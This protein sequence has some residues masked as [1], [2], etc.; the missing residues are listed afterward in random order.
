MGDVTICEDD[1]RAKLFIPVNPVLV[2]KL[3]IRDAYV[4]GAIRF[5]TDTEHRDTVEDEAGLWWRTSAAG[6]AAFLGMAA[7]TVRASLKSMVDSGILEAVEHGSRDT[8]SRTLSYRPHLPE[9][10]NT[11]LPESGNTPLRNPADVLSLF[12]NSNKPEPEKEAG[13]RKTAGPH[14]LPGDW[15]PTDNHRAK[16]ESLGVDIDATVEA[17]R[18]WAFVGDVRKKSWNGTF[19]AFLANQKPSV[20]GPVSAA[21]Q[22]DQIIGAGDRE[23]LEQLTGMR[24]DPDFGDVSPRERYLRLQDEWPSWARDNRDRLIAAA[25]SRSKPRK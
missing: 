1:F 22:V 21:S 13:D 7:N 4:L 25:V 5:R 15:Q 8:D 12:K 18:K 23:K 11:L 2:S 16:A 10:G 9:L 14:L 24:F 17:M 19:N 3:G 6:L 20:V